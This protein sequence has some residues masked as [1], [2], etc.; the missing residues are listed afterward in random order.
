M[1]ILLAECD[2]ITTAF[3]L[4]G[5]RAPHNTV[6]VVPAEAEAFHRVVTLDYDLMI[7][8]LGPRL[9]GL[10][11]L[12]PIRRR[13]DFLPVIVLG[14][15]ARIED[16]VKALDMG[17]DDYMTKPFAIVELMARVRALHRRKTC[18]PQLT[19]TIE[20]LVVDL[21][22]HTVQRGNRKIKLAP[23]EFVLLVYLIR[24]AGK[25]VSRDFIAKQVWGMRSGAKSNVVDAYVSYLR[26]K[27]DRGFG[28]R[29]IHTVYGIG[30]RIG[31]PGR[32][33][34]EQY[35]QPAKY[36]RQAKGRRVPSNDSSSAAR[37]VKQ[38]GSTAGRKS[39]VP[40]GV[41]RSTGSTPV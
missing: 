23:K 27:L 24:N 29:L 20:D 9:K 41:R 21:V 33:R 5:L 39:R 15:S 34:R 30:Y 32:G 26:R 17:A 37:V 40:R 25:N 19:V 12:K 4:R 38:A 31:D 22:A 3:L 6:E 36:S 10:G 1:R 14:Q 13:K 7:L 35:R 28:R 18:L 2:R 16:R 8:V 11:V